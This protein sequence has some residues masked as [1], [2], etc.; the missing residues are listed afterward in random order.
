MTQQ[1][2]YS[3]RDGVEKSIGKVRWSYQRVDF[4]KKT[5]YLSEN[6]FHLCM[7]VV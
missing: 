2:S 5:F 6:K 4:I 1:A 3:E 7:E